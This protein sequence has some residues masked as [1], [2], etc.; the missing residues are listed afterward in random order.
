MSFILSPHFQFKRKTVHNK[1]QE[2]FLIKKSKLEKPVPFVGYNFN[3][4]KKKALNSSSF[5]IFLL[6]EETLKQQQQKRIVSSDVAKIR[7]D[8]DCE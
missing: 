7:S 5:Y 3:S 2:N 8:F 4:S 6:L 1:I